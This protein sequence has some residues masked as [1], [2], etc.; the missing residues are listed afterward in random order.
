MAKR[1]R[2]FIPVEERMAV[3]VRH[4]V[5]FSGLSRTRLYRLMAEGKIE[6]FTVGGRRLIV[7]KSIVAFLD[8]RRA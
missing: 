1:K 7:T 5:E 3:Q 8:S 2:E 4:A 6:S